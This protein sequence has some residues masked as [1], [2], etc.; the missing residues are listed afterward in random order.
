MSSAS[1]V[2]VAAT[3]RRETADLDVERLLAA[4]VV[5]HGFEA[6]VVAAGGELGQHPRHG[7]ASEH[8]GRRRQLVGRQLHLGALVD[9]A[10]PGPADRH[11]A[12]PEGHQAVVAPVAHRRPV[13]VVAAPLAGEGG[14]LGL[15]HHVEH[16]EPGAHGE[17]QQALFELAGQLGDGHGDGVGQR[18]AALVRRATGVGPGLLRR[19]AASGPG[20]TGLQSGSS[21]S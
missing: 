15:E 11:L 3:K 19:R 6:D 2:S 9:G 12:A 5:A 14:R 13:G 20:A 8:L 17:G 7:L 1:A 16:L 21:S 10:Q 18:D 4:T